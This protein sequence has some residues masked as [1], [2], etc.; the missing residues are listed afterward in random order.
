MHDVIIIGG[1]PAGMAAAIYAIRYKLSCLIITKDVGGYANEAH[2]VEN[3]PGFPS[4]SG[5]ELMQK[6]KEHVEY[7]GGKIVEKEVKGITHKQG[8][9][10]DVHTADMI[11]PA[12]TI[13]F[14]AGSQRRKLKAPGEEKFLGKGV[15]YCATCDGYFF[16]DKVVAVIGGGDSA[17]NS[18]VHLSRLAKKVYLFYRGQ[19]LKMAPHWH[20]KIKKADN[21][22]VHCCVNVTKIDGDGSVNSIALDDGRDIDVQGVFIEIGQVPTNEIARSLGVETDEG[23]YLK[24]D[25]TMHTSVKGIFAA[26]DITTGSDKYRQIVTAASEGAI[27]A[28]SAFNH[29]NR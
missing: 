18:A 8:N 29:L 10:F 28:R 23:G 2:K 11:Y 13:I 4:I 24:V 19:K 25:Q 26:G 7:L 21:I 22:E 20:E 3:Y 9:L 27:A 15:S 6:F 12:K 16:K 1:G 5:F 14:S 17:G